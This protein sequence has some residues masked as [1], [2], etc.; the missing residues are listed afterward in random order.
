MRLQGKVALV[1]GFGSGL[2]Q[3]IAVRFAKEGAK[4]VGLSRRQEA[5]EETLQQIR[6]TGGE[7][8]FV[9]TDVRSASEVQAAVAEAIRSFGGLDIVVNSAGIR[10]TGTA[11]DISKEEWDA[12]L[13]TNLT[14][15]FLVSRAAIPELR[16]R[17]GGC[18]INISAVSG[19]HGTPGRVAYSA[20]KGAVVNLTEAMAL[21]HAAE[22]IRV[23]CICPG[24]TE[25][26]MTTITSPEQR[27]RMEQRIP[28]GH[29]GQPEDIA[30]AALY[31][32]SDAAR[33][34]TGA[35]LAVDGGL[36]LAS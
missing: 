22:H 17:G 1:T 31:L 4:V 35:I 15:S 11:T 32:A 29:I 10:L 23:N 21:D 12:V 2:G 34:V 26:P 20:S 7:A 9:P 16:R 5:G 19:I 13:D 8:L 36:H 14:G 3:A 28:L 6:A 24:P 18:I 25:T 30:E 27:S 33:Q